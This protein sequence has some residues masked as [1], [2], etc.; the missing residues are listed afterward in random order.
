MA[1]IADCVTR[2]SEKCEFFV[3]CREADVLWQVD[4]PRAVVAEHMSEQ[5]WVAVKEI[6]I[7]VSVVEELFFD[8][9]QQ[10]VWVFLDGLLP[11]LK[12]S[13]ADVEAKTSISETAWSAIVYGRRHG[14]S[15][16]GH[17]ADR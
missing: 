2:Y 7:C 1:T 6:L 14:T 5:F 11:R 8:R 17:P 10:C 15:C 3:E 13:A 16:Y 4:A 9:A 12:T